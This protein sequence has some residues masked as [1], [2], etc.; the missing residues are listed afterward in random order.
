MLISLGEENIIRV[1]L[2]ES[3]LYGDNRETTVQADIV[4]L[5][6]WPGENPT[7]TVITVDGGMFHDVPLA[8]VR[9][10]SEIRGVSGDLAYIRCPHEIPVGVRLIIER[11]LSVFDRQRNY[12]GPGKYHFTVVWPKSNLLLHLIDCAGQLMM[13]PSHKIMWGSGVRTLPVWRKWRG[14]DP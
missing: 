1:D 5:E 8:R 14:L 7:V 13:W 10:R 4:A 2:D 12:S 3:V 11:P 6:C 9:R